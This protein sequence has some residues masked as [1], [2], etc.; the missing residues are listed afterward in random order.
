MCLPL[1]L[2]HRFA[3]GRAGNLFNDCIDVNSITEILTKMHESNFQG[4]C[5]RRQEQHTKRTAW[6]RTAR[7]EQERCRVSQCTP[8]ALTTPLLQG[9]FPGHSETPLLSPS[10]RNRFTFDS[11]QHRSVTS[12]AAIHLIYSTVAKLA[13]S[14][15][16]IQNSAQGVLFRDKPPAPCCYAHAALSSAPWCCVAPCQNHS[17][18]SSQPPENHGMLQSSLLAAQGTPTGPQH[19]SSLLYLRSASSSREQSPI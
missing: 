5:V 7:E 10:S 12:R 19:E 8:R 18:N 17:T 11:P 1:G 13:S 6:E 2:W 4:V 14:W 15:Q 16:C 3:D 9:T